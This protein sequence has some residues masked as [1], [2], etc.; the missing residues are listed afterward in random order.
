MDQESEHP[1]R[2][3]ERNNGFCWWAWI[4]SIANEKQC[5]IFCNWKR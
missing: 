1:E 2:V 3:E 5:V 4:K